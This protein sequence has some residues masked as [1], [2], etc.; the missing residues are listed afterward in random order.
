MQLPM[1]QGDDIITIEFRSSQTSQA[2]G[3]EQS[4]TLS[5]YGT[6]YDLTQ[7]ELLG[8]KHFT[9]NASGCIPRNVNAN[10][11]SSSQ[12]SMAVY[13]ASSGSKNVTAIIESIFKKK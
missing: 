12:C 4:Y 8:L 11:N 10:I 1:Q 9:S 7:Y 3:T 13:N 2:S 6:T 5:Q